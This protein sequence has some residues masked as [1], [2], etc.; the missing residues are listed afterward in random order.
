MR[1]VP[2]LLEEVLQTLNLSNGKQ[3]VDATLG[4]AGHAQAMLK[5]I[6]PTGKLI[7]IDADPEAIDRATSFLADYTN[8]TFVRSNFAHLSDVLKA[9]GCQPDAILMDL[10]WSTPQFEERGRGFSFRR[11]EFL[12]MRFGQEDGDTTASSILAESTE[13]ELVDIFSEYGEEP[14]AKQIAQAIILQR[15][16][17]PI[18]TTAVLATLVE[19]VYNKH[20]KRPRRDRVAGKI[21]PATKIFQALR[22][23]VNSEL[24]AL[25]SVIPQAFDA[26]ASGGRL[27]IIS[28]HSLEDRIVKHAFKRLVLQGKATAITTKPV[29]ATEQE[30]RENPKSRSAKLRAIQKI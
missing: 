26:L 23:A 3:V 2:V 15:V 20:G 7:G 24:D 28:F 18:T 21:H 25:Q 27:G 4:D 9:H 6:G 12:D 10:G 29:T 16:D 30:R 17:T 19:E 5:Q 11:D 22:I 1:H 13:Q 8:A 14:F